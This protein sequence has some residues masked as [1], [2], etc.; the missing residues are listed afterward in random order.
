MK[1]NC[2]ILKQ[3]AP[4]KT[5]TIFSVASGHTTNGMTRQIRSAIPSVKLQSNRTVLVALPAQ[6][7]IA[8]YVWHM[9]SHADWCYVNVPGPIFA[10]TSIHPCPYPTAAE[11]PKSQMT[12]LLCHSDCERVGASARLT[13]I[14]M[15]RWLSKDRTVEPNTNAATK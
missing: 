2:N 11:H 10:V 3:D 4:P 1:A 15:S 6:N 8:S 12:R 14:S 7:G 13:N 9:H 5:P